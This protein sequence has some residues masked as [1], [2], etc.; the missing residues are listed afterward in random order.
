ML[1]WTTS[2]M[3]ITQTEDLHNAECME[4]FRN[5]TSTRRVVSMR[6]F[7]SIRSQIKT[8]GGGDLEFPLITFIYLKIW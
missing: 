3:C 4:H 7:V 8:R 5:R 1:A 6:R 2:F